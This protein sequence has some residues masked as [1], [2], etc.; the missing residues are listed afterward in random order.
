M[1]PRRLNNV[2]IVD[3][4]E[5]RLAE[6]LPLEVRFISG[7]QKKR[8]VH[9]IVHKVNGESRRLVASEVILVEIDRRPPCTI[10][11]QLIR[12]KDRNDLGLHDIEDVF[13]ELR[14][15]RSRVSKSGQ[16]CNER[17]PAWN[18]IRLH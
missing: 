6:A 17:Q 3:E 13:G 1:N 15:G 7:E 4:R 5:H 18:G 2:E 10:V 9:F 12:I 11:E 16:A 8:A 14:H